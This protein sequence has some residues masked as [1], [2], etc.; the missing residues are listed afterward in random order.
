V[1]VV[2][3]SKLALVIFALSSVAQMFGITAGYHR[4][5]AHRSF[6][7]SRQFQ[8]VLAL[9]GVLAGQNGPLWWISHHRYHHRHSDREKDLHSPT[10]GFFW[11][12][13]GWLF[14]PGC[15]QAR[16]NLVP[17]LAAM[18]ELVLLERASWLVNLACGVLLYF[19]GDAWHAADPG[20]QIN[21]LQLV[22]WGAIASKVYVYH[23][24]WSTNSI[25]HCFGQR[26]YSTRDNSRNNV[27]VALLT[28]G[29]GWH[30]N[31]H[32]FPNS[33]RHGFCWWELDINFVVLS[34]LSRL[35]I[36]WDLRLPTADR[37][38]ERTHYS[39]R[40]GVEAVRE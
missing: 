25:C 28:F 29:D 8:F 10:H 20:G 7:T 21:G 40:R 24:V 31:H 4:L 3:A 16:S 15:V 19:A 30:H 37:L 26:R 22:F 32:Y 13:M 33:A 36:V 1:F 34:L 5:L 35:G 14:S 23:A 38:T 39:C 17:D 12:H 9:F 11:S 2:G 6:K 18:W 27:V